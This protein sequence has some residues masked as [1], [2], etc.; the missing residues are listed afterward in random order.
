ML[1]RPVMVGLI[2]LIALMWAANL[3]V[4]YIDPGRADPAVN[5]I[6]GLV[7]S[8]VFALGRVRSKPGQRGDRP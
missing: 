4:G 2:I 6:F 8:A 5:A 3:V 7:A 1:P